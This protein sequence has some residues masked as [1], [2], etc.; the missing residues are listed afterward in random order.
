MNHEPRTVVAAKDVGAKGTTS[1]SA[2][3]GLIGKPSRDIELHRR[4]GR[5]RLGAATRLP[6]VGGKC[7]NAKR[8][9]GRRSRR[10]K[11]AAVTRLEDPTCYPTKYT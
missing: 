8:Q 1:A 11:Q 4:P 6:V 9:V 7:S 3:V 5:L 2:G 10:Q